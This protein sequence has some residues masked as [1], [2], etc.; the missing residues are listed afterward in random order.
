MT[1][2]PDGTVQD[3]RRN[4]FEWTS[5]SLGFQ[6]KRAFPGAT[7]RLVG[8]SAFGD[9]G[10]AWSALVA[11]VNM[12][13][14]RRDEG[15]LA[16]VALSS[17]RA[18]TSAEIHVERSRASYRIESPPPSSTA[19]P[20]DSTGGPSWAIAATTPVVTGV[21]RHARA[22][23]RRAGFDTGAFLALKGADLYFGPSARAWWSAS[24]ALTVSAS[25]A[26]THQFSQSLRNAESVVGNIFP[27]DLFMGA[28][29]PGVPVARN[30]QS[31]LSADLRPRAGLRFGLQA[32]ERGSDGLL[33][34]AP[35]EGEPFSMGAFAIGS[36]VSRGVSIDAAASAKRYSV[37]ASYGLQRMRLA[38]DGSSYI[39]ANGVAHLLQGGVS[40][41]PGATT[42]IRLGA[43]AAMGRRGTTVSDG[44]EWEANNL[45]DRGTEFGGS[46]H[47]DIA[48][49]GQ[50][51]LPSYVRVDLGLRKLWHV[52][53]G[54]RGATVALFGTATNILGRKNVL[55]Y[56]SDAAAGKPTAIEM[57]PLAPLVIGLDWS[58]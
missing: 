56:A 25:Y 36:S 43:S 34:V 4:N 21:A 20:S 24:S 26:R 40:V 7:L 30:Q 41:F 28:G 38:Y 15:F 48:T 9:A 12:T 45:L 1:T 23:G 2:A 39:P 18:T 6:W 14:S 17:P 52:G 42:S 35:R 46:P 44:F 32:Y 50:A 8:W 27:V 29:A 57:R 33:L 37:V 51:R 54:E 5:Q 11:P 31:V 22:I 13:A 3:L 19:S 47:Y 58:F 55:T 16:A 53:I 10:S 49:L